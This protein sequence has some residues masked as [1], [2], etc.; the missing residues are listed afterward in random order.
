[1]VMLD[2]TMLSDGV[3]GLGLKAQVS[4][5]TRCETWGKSLVTLYEHNTSCSHEDDR[6]VSLYK[7]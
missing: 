1:M 5:L 2:K 3:R 7:N 6:P 4:P